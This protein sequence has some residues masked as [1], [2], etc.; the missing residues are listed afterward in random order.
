MSFLARGERESTGG[1]GMRSRRLILTFLALLQFLIAVDVTVVNIALP[2]IGEDFGVGVRQL[3]WVVT[4]YTVVGGGLLMLGGRVADLLGRRR[5]LLAGAAIFG[6][7]SLAAGLA[8]SL[9]LLV[10]ARFAQGAGEA[11]ASPAA[12]SLLALLFPEPQARSRALGVWAAVASSG[13]VLGFLLS[14]VITQ[15]FHWRWIFLIN[16]PLVAAVLCAV[17][18]LIRADGPVGRRPLDLP[19]ALLLTATPLLLVY[20]IIEL[21]EAHR[22]IA[23]ATAAV[24][25]G[26][27]CAVAFVVVERR[28]PH[29]LVPLTLF[30]TRVRVVA[31]AATALVS[32]ALSTAFLLLTLSLQQERGLSPI[33]AGFSFLPF[34]ITLI[35]TSLVVP[36]LVKRAGLNAAATLG[37]AVT[38]AGAVSLAVA[39]QPETPFIAVM[40]GMVLIS[41][42]MGIALI[43]L[44]NA[45]LHDV[46]EADAGMASGVQRCADQLGGA[47]GVALYVGV[48]FSPLLGAGADPYLVAYGMAVAGLVA[49][50]SAVLSLSRRGTAQVT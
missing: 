44:Q 30:T 34:A 14:G 38:A 8:P 17:W 48:G 36:G 29:P 26:V 40:P 39:A 3:T 10:L 32:A 16:L 27:V 2:S 22:D 50:A 1:R 41:G 19:G 21:G 7:A 6:L 35:L 13:L 24:V 45:A 18:I 49:A 28:S 20:G 43:A 5:T 15:H 23:P 25:L 33:A 47:S 42:G 37:I 11:L 9:E 4:G 31:N 12:M 46:T